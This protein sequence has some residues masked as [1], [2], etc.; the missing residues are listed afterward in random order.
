LAH[1]WLWRARYGVQPV[2]SR[3]G[4]GFFARFASHS[5][6]A[7]SVF[8]SMIT[9]R[10]VRMTT[11]MAINRKWIF[12]LKNGTAVL[13]WGDGMA[14][15][16]SSGKFLLYGPDDFSHQIMDE[17]LESLKQAGRIASFDAQTV[18]IFAWDI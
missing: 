3:G 11:K 15:E 10:D 2:N 6:L 1:S 16:L 5:S 8:F 18:S 17:E 7:N 12:V 14:Q 4:K 13:D 9:P